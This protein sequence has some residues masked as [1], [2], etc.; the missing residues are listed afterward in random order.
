MGQ[1]VSAITEEL[2]RISEDTTSSHYQHNQ[3]VGNLQGKTTSQK[4]ESPSSLS[5]SP[6]IYHEATTK[7]EQDYAFYHH[8]RDTSTRNEFATTSFKQNNSYPTT[9]RPYTITQ[10]ETT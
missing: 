2:S 7:N 10:S 6:L 5:H 4:R 1:T 8:T 9:S 3:Q